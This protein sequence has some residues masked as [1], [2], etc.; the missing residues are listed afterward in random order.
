MATQPLPSSEQQRHSSQYSTRPAP[1]SVTI[2]RRHRSATHDGLGALP[3]NRSASGVERPTR[4][5]YGVSVGRDP[6]FVLRDGRYG[7]PGVLML[8]QRGQLVVDV[9]SPASRQ[10]PS[11]LTRHCTSCDASAGSPALVKTGPPALLGETTDAGRRLPSS[12][13]PNVSRVSAETW[14]RLPGTARRSPPHGMG[15][16]NPRSTPTPP[17]R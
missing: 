13:S 1:F 10:P 5:G 3:A 17:S 12:W 16:S 14:R 9:T 8:T 4:C 15:P 11:G 6:G 2:G 7:R